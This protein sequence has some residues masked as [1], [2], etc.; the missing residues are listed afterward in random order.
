MKEPDFNEV[1]SILNNVASL[2]SPFFSIFN[3]YISTF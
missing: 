2:A 1:K 3:L